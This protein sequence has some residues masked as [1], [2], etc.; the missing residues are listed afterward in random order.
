M[1]T[2][3]V[4]NINTPISCQHL[5]RVTQ[6]SMETAAR[7]WSRLAFSRRTDCK[8]SLETR[9]EY[10]ITEVK[11]IFVKILLQR[12]TLPRLNEPTE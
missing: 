2:Q 8:V 5:I 12:Y 9:V 1:T 11:K 4:T 6:L 10:A 7:T 3:A